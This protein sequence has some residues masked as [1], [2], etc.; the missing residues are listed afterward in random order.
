[1]QHVTRSF[2]LVRSTRTSL[3]RRA[4]VA[5]ATTVV[6][7]TLG[8][9][10]CTSRDPSPDQ[11]QALLVK[12]PEILYAA[13]EAH[14]AEFIA[15][16]NKAAEKT[17]ASQAKMKAASDSARIE[18][19][20]SHPK[21][22]TIDHRA[23]LGNPN[24]PITIVEYTDFECPY[25]RQER[26]V[27]VQLF[28]VYGDKVR[29]VVKQMPIPE[30]HPKAMDA[31]LM[32]EALAK[33]DPTKAYKLYDDLYEHQDEFAKEGQPYLERVVAQLGADVGRAVRDQRS[34]AIQ[35]V[36]AADVE[37][38]KKFGFTGTPGF[39]VNGVSLQGAYPLSAFQQ[40]IDRQLAARTMVSGRM[41]GAG[42]TPDV[43]Q[44]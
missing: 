33:Q 8:L 26:D 15:V 37:E 38:G 14:P 19:E 23:V 31:A 44:P 36:V 24:A 35:R 12:K 27:L 21:H 4:P 10:S 39:L 11:I 42:V 22:A 28:K 40:L 6:I 9:S 20:L 34:D 43:K 25:C 29:L 41:S 17:Q 30:L 16:L 2:E 7:V 5:L 32:F 13:I 3:L 1:M 18:D